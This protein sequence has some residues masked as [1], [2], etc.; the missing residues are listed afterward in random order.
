MKE[1]FWRGYLRRT[2][3][4]MKSRIDNRNKIIIEHMGC[5]FDETWCRYCKMDKKQT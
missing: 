3:L 2:K 5:F 1:I 4:I